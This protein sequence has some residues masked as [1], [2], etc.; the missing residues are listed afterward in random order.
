M[1]ITTLTRKRIRV[2]TCEGHLEGV[3]KPERV[4]HR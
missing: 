3:E 4:D 1:S 2:W